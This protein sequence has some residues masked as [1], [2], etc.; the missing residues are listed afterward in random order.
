MGG[1][2]WAGGDGLGNG[3]DGGGLG[4]PG[5]GGDAGSGEGGGGSGWSV[6]PPPHAQHTSLDRACTQL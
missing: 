3:A 2:G 1:G 5:G 6:V 4:S